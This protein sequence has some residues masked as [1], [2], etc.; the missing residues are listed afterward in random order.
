MRRLKAVYKNVISFILG[1]IFCA[2]TTVLAETC[3]TT[4][5]SS[6]VTYG[7]N[8]TAQAEVSSLLTQ[9]GNIDSRVTTLEGRFNNTTSYFDGDWLKITSTS[10]AN[11]GASIFDA[12]GNVRSYFYYEPNNT[13][14]VLRSVQPPGNTD[15]QLYLKGSPITLASG[16]DINLNG[17][18]KINGRGVG[19]YYSYAP[20]AT[21]LESVSTTTFTSIGS[22]TLEPGVWVVTIS[23]RFAANANGFRDVRIFSDSSLST[24]VGLTAMATAQ[25][26]SGAYVHAKM[27]YV[28]TI[29]SSST[30]YIGARQ[31]SG[32][33]LEATPRV[34][35]VRIA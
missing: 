8:S 17:T 32:T 16:G 29:N 19:T 12:S 7:N 1:I 2:C 30:Y 4:L 23:V 25:G 21:N 18:V 9:A 14:T 11:R 31:N 27:A 34:Y 22:F 13:R 5:N 24:T 15:A 28:S 3:Y 35:C 6:N 20:T 33:T 10:S 26:I